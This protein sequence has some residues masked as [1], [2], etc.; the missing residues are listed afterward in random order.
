MRDPLSN[1]LKLTTWDCGS[2]DNNEISATSSYLTFLRLSLFE[3]QLFI[4]TTPNA[5]AKVKH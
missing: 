5:I 2:D 4:H 1:L 3:Y